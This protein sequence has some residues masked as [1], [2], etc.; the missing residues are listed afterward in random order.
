[1]VKGVLAADVYSLVAREAGNIVIAGIRFWICTSL[2]RERLGS[3]LSQGY[4]YVRTGRH[5]LQYIWHEALPSR[6]SKGWE[7]VE[8]PRL[9]VTTLW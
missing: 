3:G 8:N 1:M 4:G 2:Q 9:F 7:S 5:H 6:L